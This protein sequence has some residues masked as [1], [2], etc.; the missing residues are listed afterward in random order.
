MTTLG[1]RDLGF[2]AASSGELWTPAQ[3]TTALWLDAADAST[4]SQSSGAVDEWRDKSGN[5]RHTTASTTAR[6]VVTSAGLGGK[7]VITFDGTNDVLTTT[8]ATGLS[9]SFAVFA[10]VVPLRN[11]AIEGYVVSEVASYSNYWLSFGRGSPAPG[12]K[13][14]ISMFDGANNPISDF[15]T[16]PTLGQGYIMAGVRDTVASPRK[17]FYYQDET[18]RGNETD[19]TSLIA[20]GY[21]LLRIGGQVNQPNRYGNFRIAE[22]V[23]V[24]S[25]PSTTLRQQMS[26]YLAHKWGLTANLPSD[27]PYKSTPPTV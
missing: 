16:L 15:A 21:S 8:L 23:I 27:H 26:G 22:V 9:S 25:L 6:P 24:P 10:V 18:L 1:L 19:T 3:I 5:A 14:G 2:V 7:D 20:P 17:L 11:Q 4:I 13:M 12:Q